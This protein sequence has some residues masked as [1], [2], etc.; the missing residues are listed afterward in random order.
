MSCKLSQKASRRI[1]EEWA[2]MMDIKA[3]ALEAIEECLKH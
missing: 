3:T 2:R 1:I